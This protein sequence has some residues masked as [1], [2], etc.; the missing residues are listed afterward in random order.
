MRYKGGGGQSGMSVA[1]DSHGSRGAGVLVSRRGRI[2]P[3]DV[4]RVK[5]GNSAARRR[6]M[7]GQ[8][9]TPE[10]REVCIAGARH[11]LIPWERRSTRG[12]GC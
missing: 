9:G 1:G 12:P 6:S 5:K 10:Y 7:S 4:G 8:L 2:G 3:G 11:C